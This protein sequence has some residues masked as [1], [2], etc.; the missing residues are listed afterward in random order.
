M[1]TQHWCKD[2]FYRNKLFCEKCNVHVNI[3]TRPSTHEKTVLPDSV[4]ET[5]VD[6]AEKEPPEPYGVVRAQFVTLEDYDHTDYDYGYVEN[7]DGYD[8]DNKVS[9][10]NDNQ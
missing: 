10:S 9:N 1:N 2:F 4:A 3:C 7:K 5:Y 8:N 6:E